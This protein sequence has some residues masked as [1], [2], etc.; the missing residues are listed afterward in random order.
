M[1]DITTEVGDI[2]STVRGTVRGVRGKSR[3]G[4]STDVGKYQ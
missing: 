3:K 2:V 4:I 1:R